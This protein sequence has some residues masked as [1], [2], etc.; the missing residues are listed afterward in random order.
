MTHRPAQ[1]PKP[2]VFEPEYL[3]G[4]RDIFERKIV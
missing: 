1:P 3:E 2:V 4:V